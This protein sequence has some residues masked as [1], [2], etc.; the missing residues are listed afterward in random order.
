MC[1]A[2][3]RAAQKQRVACAVQCKCATRCG[4]RKAQD[5]LLFSCQHASWDE[6][7]MG[8]GPPMSTGIRSHLAPGGTDPGS[9]MPSSARLLS[10]GGKRSGSSTVAAGPVL[11]CRRCTA[12]RRAVSWGLPRHTRTLQQQI[13]CGHDLPPH[14]LARITGSLGFAAS[15]RGWSSAS[16]NMPSYAILAQQNMGL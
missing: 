15:E 5:W 11:P 3:Q 1:R 12:A 16:S 2:A 13:K 7:H 6:T 4:S 14:Y 10:L 9:G 8:S